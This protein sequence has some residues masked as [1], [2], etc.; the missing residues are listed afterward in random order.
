MN[1]HSTIRLSQTPEF[2]Q[3]VSVKRMKALG[4]EEKARERGS[5]RMTPESK[6]Q[7]F[8]LFCASGSKNR[9]HIEKRKR[10]WAGR[11]IGS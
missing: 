2:T 4:I 9:P 7:L 8:P 5:E 10:Q 6:V 1:G 11:N 3:C